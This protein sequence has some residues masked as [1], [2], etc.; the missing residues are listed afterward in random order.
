MCCFV[1]SRFI[2]TVVCWQSSIGPLLIQ[3]PVLMSHYCVFAFFQT[4]LSVWQR[5][6]WLYLCWFHRC[7]VCQVTICKNQS[8]QSLGQAAPRSF[9]PP[10][11]WSVAASFSAGGK[12]ERLCKR[13]STCQQLLKIIGKGLQQDGEGSLFSSSIWWIFEI[14][15]Q[16]WSWVQRNRTVRE[17]KSS[18]SSFEGIQSF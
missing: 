11:P 18:A 7:L 14:T 9:S 16:S 3:I 2:S 10:L 5:V 6:L 17:E 4:Y 8:A 15:K 1:V 13:T 12:M